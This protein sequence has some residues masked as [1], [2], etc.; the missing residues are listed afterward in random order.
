MHVCCS[1]G[2]NNN[3]YI[4]DH[5]HRWF[6]RF[7]QK[8]MDANS[9]LADCRRYARNILTTCISKLFWRTVKLFRSFGPKYPTLWEEKFVFS[10]VS[11][12]SPSFQVPVGQVN[13]L[14]NCKNLK[15]HFNLDFMS[16]DWQYTF[17]MGTRCWRLRN[18]SY[19]PATILWACTSFKIPVLH[20]ASD[21]CYCSVAS[22]W[23]TYRRWYYSTR[24]LE[25]GFPR[26]VSQ[27]DEKLRMALN[28]GIACL[29][30]V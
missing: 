9:L 26:E 21:S 23:T 25:M 10:P 3:Q 6:R 17:P 24:Q 7:Y 19:W 15:T 22:N 28:I 14:F 12:F 18:P 2:V 29:L 4:R 30:G 27:H 11:S 20:W 5:Y 1:D 8:L 16:N 13:P